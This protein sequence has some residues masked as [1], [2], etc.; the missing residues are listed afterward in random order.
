MKPINVYTTGTT[1]EDVY[2]VSGRVNG[3]RS[4]SNSFMSNHSSEANHLKE[5]W[6]AFDKISKN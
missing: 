1:K 3:K 2:K 4:Q 5:R 6:H